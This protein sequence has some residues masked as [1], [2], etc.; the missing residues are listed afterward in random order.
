MGCVNVLKTVAFLRR[1]L[2]VIGLRLQGAPNM[3]N[4]LDNLAMFILDVLRHDDIESI[5][6]I[7]S[8]LND[9]SGT[10][11][12][13]DHWPHDFLESE[14]TSKLIELLDGRFVKAA[15]YDPN[16]QAAVECEYK[17]ISGSKINH[18]GI[19]FTLTPKGRLALESWKPPNPN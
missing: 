10:I 8:L 12:W 7:L 9:N 3:D 4:N 17:L 15:R 14:V 11:G 1:T 2:C 16:Q 13:R 19:W 5:P 6:S 18:D